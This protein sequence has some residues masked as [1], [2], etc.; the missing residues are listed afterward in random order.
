MDCDIA[1]ADFS[2]LMAAR[3]KNKCQTGTDDESGGS[4]TSERQ[5]A[6]N[7]FRVAGPVTI[8]L[9]TLGH[10]VV[11]TEETDH[12]AELVEGCPRPD[13]AI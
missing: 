11:S 9:S 5:A 7:R 3:H 2:H 1:D 4:S 6:N 12:I 10:A 8:Y 13:L